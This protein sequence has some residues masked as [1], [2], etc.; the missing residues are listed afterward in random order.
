EAYRVY[1]LLRWRDQVPYVQLSAYAVMV[2]L[3][4]EF[5]DRD[6]AAA[7]YG[8]LRPHADLFVC[9]GAGVIMILGPVHYPLG[10]AAAIVGR[11][12]DAAHHLR[13]AIDL[14]T[15]A[16]MPGAA[17]AAQYRLARV[18]ARRKRSGD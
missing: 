16:G 17:V 18:L 4:D 7:I 5:G 11:F 2:D 10:I 14:S 15:R 1:R 6:T 3:A 13:L 8:L 12:D 9:S